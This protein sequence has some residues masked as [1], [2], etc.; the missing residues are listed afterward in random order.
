MGI[1]CGYFYL[2]KF[3]VVSD[4]PGLLLF[5]NVNRRIIFIVLAFL[6]L[7]ML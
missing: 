4:A 5:I 2:H 6:G 3:T 7:Y 1:Y